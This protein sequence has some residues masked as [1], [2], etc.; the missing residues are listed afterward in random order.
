MVLPIYGYFL[1]DY[2]LAVRKI[3][4]GIVVLNQVYM[5]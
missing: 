4:K 5:D 3:S 2:R 1:A